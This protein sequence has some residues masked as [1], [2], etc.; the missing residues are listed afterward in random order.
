MF[1]DR[2]VKIALLSIISNT[3]LII[4]KVIAGILSG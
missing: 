1:S 3:I 2:K 4:F